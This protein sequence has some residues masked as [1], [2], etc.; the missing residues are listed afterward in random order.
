M[1]FHKVLE[2]TKIRHLDLASPTT[3]RPSTT[4]EETIKKMRTVRCACALVTEGG[5]L[6]GIFTERDVLSKVIGAPESLRR[7]V[8]DLM[9]PNPITLKVD[10]SLHDAID[11]MSEGGYRNIPIVDD[12]GRAV[13]SLPASEIVNFIVSHFPKA[14]YNL[15][16]HLEQRMATQEGA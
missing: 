9:T 5:K 4:V 3:V 12:D 7:P 14:V 8:R 15:P 13:A 10:D 6:V 2:D 16:P 1:S 11:T